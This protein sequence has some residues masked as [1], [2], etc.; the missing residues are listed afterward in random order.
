MCQHKLFFVIFFHTSLAMLTVPYPK[1]TFQLPN[2]PSNWMCTV[3]ITVATF[4]NYTTSDITERFLASN[5]EKIIPTVGV[6]LNR[7]IRI[8]PVNSFFEP[9]TIN[10]LIDATV[11]GSSYVFN[12]SGLYSYFSRNEYVN[13]EWRH[14]IFIVIY[15]SCE[16]RYSSTHLDSPHRLFYHS[17]DCGY[18]QTFPNQVFV[19]DHLQTLWNITDA[20]HNIHYRQLPLAIRRSIST[21]KYAWDK[22]DSSIRTGHCLA[23]RWDELSKMIS[24]KLDEYAVHHYQ[25]FL[26]FTAVVNAT[27][28][29]KLYGE[30]MTHTKRH[31]A[32]HSISVHAIDSVNPRV[33]YCDR[34]SDSPRLRPLRLSSPFSF[35]TWVTL[36][37][38]LILCAIA[39]SFTILGTRPAAKDWTTII[40][41]KTIF[42]SLFELIIGLF[43]NDVGKNNFTKPFIGLLVIYLGN[44]Y[45]NYLTI[46]LVYP[47]AGVA[48]QN[49][50]ELLDLDFHVTDTSVGVE[51]IVDERMLVYLNYHLEIDESKWDKHA[52]AV[53][54]WFKLMPYNEERIID[55]L[56]SV[57][58]KNAWIVNK[59]YYMQVHA[60][61]L[62]NERNYP[63]SCHFVKRPFGHQFIEFLFFNPK[64][65]E[66]KWWTAKFLDHGLFDFWKRLDSHVD[67]LHQ[68]RVSLQMRSNK[69]N[70]SSIESYDMSNFIGQVHLNVFYI[71]ISIL[72]A[73]CIAIFLVESA[74]EKARELSLFVFTKFKHV[75]L[76][77]LSTVIRF[78][79][80]ISRLIGSLYLSRNPS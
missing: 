32:R 11:Q 23:S 46:E 76:E 49:L 62:L 64:A 45:K 33:L 17:P 24:C 67:T 37:F 26:N 78:L 40:F 42:N 55:E 71:A 77:L 39:R 69:S 36:V 20:T 43:E 15:F 52:R 66:F 34:N 53:G 21:P 18:Q 14:S 47:R 57:T 59:P 44:N 61:N 35:E 30:L 7:N 25:H 75:S 13:R 51:G 31:L 9:C 1:Q 4:A 80:L 2:H 74:M 38:L 28:K 27:D 29:L 63:L 8:A 60:L 50:T 12:W 19:P 70:S 54:R 3:H 10:V 41:I 65:E 48:I 68:R 16:Y 72:T 79:Y 56:A 58:S 5:R 22:H 73:I 6:M